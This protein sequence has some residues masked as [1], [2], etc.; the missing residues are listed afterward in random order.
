MRPRDRWFWLG[1]AWLLALPRGAWAG[2]AAP[3][4]DDPHLVTRL[5]ESAL[6]RLQAISFFLFILLACTVVVRWLWNVVQRDF[7]ALPRLSLKAALA[8]VLLWGLLFVIVL[9]MIS[10]ARE[11]MTPGAWK[12]QG[13]TYRLD[14]PPAAEP[15][16]ESVRRQHLER[17]RTALWQ[18]AATHQGRFPTTGEVPAI[19]REL[20]EIPDSGGLRYQYVPGLSAGHSPLPLV[21]EPELDPDRRFV[22][23]VN[24]DI[25]RVPSRDLPTAG[26]DG[27]P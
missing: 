25:L 1:C 27:A 26:K 14:E 5:S 3:L 22:L 19:P 15:D 4:P 24:G 23:R 13:Y 11:L 17:L 8:G 16:P 12:K 10:G 6:F 9:A 20:W 7:P 18:F 2:M 21:S